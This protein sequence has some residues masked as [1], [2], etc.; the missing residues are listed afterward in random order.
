MTSQPPSGTARRASDRGDRVTNDEA[1]TTASRFIGIDLASEAKRTGVAIIEITGTHATA[2]LAPVGFVA[3][4]RGLVDIVDRS[5]VV[6]LDSPLG[7]PD[8][9]VSAV[10]AHRMSARWPTF[11]HRSTD[12]IRESLRHR[13]TD[14]FVRSLDL[15]S[16]PLS[17]SSDLIGVVAMR[18]AWLQSAWAQKWGCLEPRDG[19]GRLVET[20]PA[21]A[22]RAWDMLA[23]RGVR[24]KGG[25]T[26]AQREVQRAERERIM[27]EIEEQSAHW[28]D[29]SAALRADA[30][31]SDHVLDAL[32]SALVALAARVGATHRAPSESKEAAR[33]EGWIH[34]PSETFDSLG[35]HLPL[36]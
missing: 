27:A 26:A 13:T 14:L 2:G 28:L 35:K 22:L 33:R 3:D 6:G 25:G 4:D 21:A 10:T 19:T 20:Y 16:T 18:G 29:V 23:R 7:W 36:D 9:F 31:E 1:E 8:D 11:E 5:T 34:V 17:V 15:G 12:K 30:V 24:Y 32:V